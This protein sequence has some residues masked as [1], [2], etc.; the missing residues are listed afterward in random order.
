[1]ARY[2][3][4]PLEISLFDYLTV[5]GSYIFQGVKLFYCHNFK[6]CRYVDDD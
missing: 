3:F 1:M 5:N 4:S 6:A 2:A